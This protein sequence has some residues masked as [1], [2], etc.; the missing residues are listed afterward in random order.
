MLAKDTG[1][2]LPVYLV[3]LALVPTSAAW[4]T[5]PLRQ[6]RAVLAAFLGVLAVYLAIR[7]EVLGGFGGYQEDGH[8]R[9]LRLDWENALRFTRDAVH[10]VLA[11]GSHPMLAIMSCGIGATLVAGG[12]RGMVGRLSPVIVCFVIGLLPAANTVRLDILTGENARFLYLP[13]A[14]AC[15]GLGI[16]LGQASTIRSARIFGTLAVILL[17]TNSWTLAT[18]NQ[19]WRVAGDT[20]ETIVEQLRT[21][22]ARRDYEF[23]FIHDLPDSYR[24][25]FVF[26]NGIDTAVRLFVSKT[27][28]F[29]AHGEISRAVWDEHAARRRSDPR[30]C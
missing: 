9:H 5:R 3:Y 10:S 28:E 23:L 18:I 17:G 29:P 30:R 13:S 22:T 4:P 1:M 27:I 6:S 14:F 15:V 11:P 16:L 25:A 2:I 7:F 20:A 21:L 8:S 26:R 24:G 12:L 19:R